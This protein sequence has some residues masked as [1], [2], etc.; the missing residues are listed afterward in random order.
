MDTNYLEE[1]F[2]RLSLLEDDFDISVDANK[3]DELRSFINDDINEIPEEEIIDVN[4]EDESELQDNYIGKVILECDCC[5]SRLYKDEADIVIDEESGLA[6]I[7]EACPVC[8]NELGYTIIGKIEPFDKDREIEPEEES[9]V[10]ETD[11][12][13]PDDIEVKDEVKESLTNRVARKHLQE[14]K[15][16]DVCPHCGKNPCVCESCDN[17]SLEEDFKEVAITT[18]DQKLEMTSDEGGKVTVTTEPIEEELP[19]E[20]SAEEIVP[21]DT[22]EESAIEANSADEEEL[23][24]PAEDESDSSEEQAEDEDE[25]EVEIEDFDEES[26]DEMSE[27]YLHKVYD[28]V[29][30]YKTTGIKS[31]QDALV[32]E[33]LITL[34]S[35][36][37]TNTSFVFNNASVSKRGKVVLE[38][39]NKTFTKSNKSFMVRGSL[40]G[41]KYLPESLIYNYKTKQLNESTNS[42]E[43][44]RVYGRIKKK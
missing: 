41:N 29:K 39:Y 2:K 40:D 21:L 28:D 5:H 13:P 35:G 8:N 16:E 14:A 3:V 25:E 36:K 19:E 4:A 23:E 18:D 27:S 30:S 17:E 43:T 20:E 12:L 9:K 10:E 22:E 6:N 26:F 24:G 32:V 44:V 38:G 33:G 7:E 15:E 42:K 31:Y 1:A 34:K 37:T 11:E